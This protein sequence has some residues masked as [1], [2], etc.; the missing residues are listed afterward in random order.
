MRALPL[1]LSLL[2]GC[3]AS[4]DFGTAK[5]QQQ[6]SAE[7]RAQAVNA[8]FK[9]ADLSGCWQD[10]QIFPPQGGPGQAFRL[11]KI[12]TDSYA[13][14]DGRQLNIVAGHAERIGTDGSRL[15]GALNFAQPPYTIAFDA[16]GGEANFEDT[17]LGWQWAGQDCP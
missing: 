4:A 3:S 16:D 17:R 8:S 1:V 15:T 11:R 6:L 14:A 5:S 13:A 12:A 7:D 10:V 9:P 2:V